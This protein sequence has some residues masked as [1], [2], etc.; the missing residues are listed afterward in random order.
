MLQSTDQGRLCNNKDLRRIRGS[1]WGG[2]IDYI[3]QVAW[4]QVQKGIGEVGMEG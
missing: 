4:G 3:S 1:S 2:E